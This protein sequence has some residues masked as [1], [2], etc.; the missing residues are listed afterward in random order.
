M[1][2]HMMGRAPSESAI[3]P[4]K[5]TKG[6]KKNPTSKSKL[7]LSWYLNTTSSV[8]H[9][10]FGRKSLNHQWI[11]FPSKLR[12]MSNILLKSLGVSLSLWLLMISMI[13]RQQLWEEPFGLWVQPLMQFS[14]K[15]ERKGRNIGN[16]RECRDEGIGGI[17]RHKT[18]Y[19]QRRDGEKSC[20]LERKGR[21]NLKKVEW[22]S[23]KVHTH[24]LYTMDAYTLGVGVSCC[25]WWLLGK[26]L[27]TV[28][29]T[30]DC[31]KV[32]GEIS[33][34]VFP[35]PSVILLFNWIF[36]FLVSP[37][38]VHPPPCLL[39]AVSKWTEGRKK[40]VVQGK[41]GYDIHPFLG[42]A[43]LRA[44]NN[45]LLSTWKWRNL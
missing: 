21:E 45:F 31:W 27:M 9:I 26:Q 37:I 25:H 32:K 8:L 40:G 35:A 6:T 22:E 33:R 20:R 1:V 28:L 7:F 12:Q 13:F 18:S 4:S 41:G 16:R 42:A 44:G 10:H 36:H 43:C 39:L 14:R 24:T 23:C 3:K 30:P 19:W 17:C 29:A 38:I 11:Y 34:W 15:V 2:L 5:C